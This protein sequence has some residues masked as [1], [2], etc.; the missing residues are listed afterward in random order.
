V[1]ASR[2]R[3]L[4]DDH[5]DTMRAISGLTIL[6]EKAGE[7]AKAEPL[8]RECLAT[9]LRTAP[10]EWRT[11]DTQSHLG[12]VLLGQGKL[13]EAEPLLLSGYEGLQAQEDRLDA[14]RK[15]RLTRA[16][17]RLVKLYEA[18]FDC[19]AVELW[20]DK[21]AAYQAKIGAKPPGGQTDE[22]P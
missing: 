8:L 16:I 5:R 10:G 2:R 19:E 21:L 1:L 15:I 6:Y 18:K 20:S 17:Q 3:V 9:R 14:D 4:G 7:Y 12:G 13:E 22:M 11:F